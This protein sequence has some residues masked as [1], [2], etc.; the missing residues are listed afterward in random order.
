MKIK[1]CFFHKY[2]EEKSGIITVNYKN[3]FSSRQKEVKLV[4]KKCE[5]CGKKK[6]FFI[7]SMN[8]KTSIAVWAAE[9][10]LE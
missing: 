7:N 10:S 9:N 5:K 6:A 2:V 1:Y 8:E 3:I 4:I